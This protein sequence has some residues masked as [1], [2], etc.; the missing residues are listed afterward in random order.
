MLRTPYAGIIDALASTALTAPLADANGHVDALLPLARAPYRIVVSPSTA[1]H[2]QS[3]IHR[4]RLIVPAPFPLRSVVLFRPRGPAQR[5]CP[6]HLEWGA[7]AASSRDRA[8]RD[9]DPRSLVS[10]QPMVVADCAC[11]SPLRRRS[12]QDSHRGSQVSFLCLSSRE[13]TL[14][15]AQSAVPLAYHRDVPASLAITTRRG[16]VVRPAR[17]YRLWY[18]HTQGEARD[19][20]RG[21]DGVQSG[22]G[23]VFLLGSSPSGTPQPDLDGPPMLTED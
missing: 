5:N 22:R 11:A 3:L 9:R 7:R 1:K 16:P 6:A 8:E 13:I 12:T 21:E 17:L 14:T 10:V 23:V 15:C 4:S 18:A 19:S 2:L 20:G